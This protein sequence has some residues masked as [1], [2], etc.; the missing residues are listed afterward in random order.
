MGRGLRRGRG[1]WAGLGRAWPERCRKTRGRA[2]DGAWVKCGVCGTEPGGT[3]WRS[4]GLGEGLGAGRATADP[5]PARAAPAGAGGRVSPRSAA[6]LPSPG[7]WVRLGLR[8]AASGRGPGLR[9]GSERASRVSA[10]PEPSS[11]FQGATWCG[12]PKARLTV[13]ASD[14]RAPAR[15]PAPQSAAGR[16]PF[17]AAPHQASS[18]CGSLR[19]TVGH[20]ATASRC[21]VRSPPASRSFPLP[22][23]PHLPPGARR[24]GDALCERPCLRVWADH[25]S[26][27]GLG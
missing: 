17:P 16:G 8:R 10:G 20:C 25:A 22:G 2:W 18:A 23:C 11:G 15:R 5:A 9:G 27:V 3:G 13:A 6:P 21:G 4:Q 1:D 12:D 24:G 19:V 14:I 7:W 26:G